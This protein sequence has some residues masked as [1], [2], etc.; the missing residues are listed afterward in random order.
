MTSAGLM[1]NVSV[2]R[3][4]RWYFLCAVLLVPASLLVMFFFRPIGWA[5]VLL[6][7]SLCLAVLLAYQGVAER[8][9]ERSAD[10]V[11]GEE[12]VRIGR[13]SIWG[14]VMAMLGVSALVM[15]S[16]DFEPQPYLIFSVVVFALAVVVGAGRAVVDLR[17]ERAS[18]AAARAAATGP[19]PTAG[20]AQE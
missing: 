16:R 15:A 8:R 2:M 13:Q 20:P 14:V 3:A 1:G 6:L 19:V 9:W 11:D 18:V 4:S 7:A 10:A 5:V 17:A 12:P